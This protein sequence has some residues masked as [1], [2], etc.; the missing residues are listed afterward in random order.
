M[1]YKKKNKIEMKIKFQEIL[2]P[3]KVYQKFQRKKMVE[4][5]LKIKQLEPKL[6]KF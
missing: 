6:K 1:N 3:L 5:E 2:V 4:V